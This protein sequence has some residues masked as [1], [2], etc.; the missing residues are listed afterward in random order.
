MNRNLLIAT[1]A[2][3]GTALFA[4][5]GTLKPAAQ[6]EVVTA[7]LTSPTDAPNVLPPIRYTSEH[8][9]TGTHRA[10]TDF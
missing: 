2:V 7:K 9:E 8:D 3:A 1:F 6:A 5:N 10:L 4:L